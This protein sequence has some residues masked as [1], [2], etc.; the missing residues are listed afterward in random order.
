MLRSE[1]LQRYKQLQAYL[2][3]KYLTMQKLITLARHVRG[4]R[5]SVA[6]GTSAQHAVA[7]VADLKQWASERA[8]SYNLTGVNQ[9]VE[10]AQLF[11]MP[12]KPLVR[13]PEK[14]FAAVVEA[15]AGQ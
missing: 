9:L 8:A 3:S 5:T 7:T 10:V 14:E 15:A 4:Q 1:Q 12:N 13:M 11:S 2:A 6:L